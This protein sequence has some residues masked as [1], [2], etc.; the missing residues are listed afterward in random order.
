MSTEEH[1]VLN[2]LEGIYSAYLARK[3]GEED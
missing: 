3:I 2:Q 1:A